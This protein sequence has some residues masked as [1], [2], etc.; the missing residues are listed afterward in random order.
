MAM[1]SPLIVCVATRKWL[2][3][4][5]AS[6]FYQSSLASQQ[7]E[8]TSERS[9][10]WVPK[11]MRSGSGSRRGEEKSWARELS[12]G[13]EPKRFQ[14]MAAIVIFYS[15]AIGN[16]VCC[17]DYC[18]FRYNNIKINYP[19]HNFIACRHIFQYFLVMRRNMLDG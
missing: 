3:Q 13:R 15:E 17:S 12:G 8:A 16:L 9:H 7:K 6:M 4:C 2:L 11:K 14:V 1:C 5:S 19:R 10:S 18:M